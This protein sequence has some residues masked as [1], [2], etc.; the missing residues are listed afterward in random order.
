MLVIHCCWEGKLVKSL[1]K[2]VWR[3]LKKLKIE[4]PYAPA[5]PLIGTYTKKCKAS[6]NKEACTPMFI[7]AL[8]IIPKVWK[9]TRCSITD[10]WIKKIWYLYLMEFYS[11][12]KKNEIFSFIGKWVELEN[13]N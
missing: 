8:F 7:A 13:N 11:A 10:E 5:I 3:L 9:Q 1:W 4:L 6:Y 2:T 12:S